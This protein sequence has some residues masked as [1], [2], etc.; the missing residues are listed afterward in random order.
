M[1]SPE[2][3]RECEWAMVD[4]CRR[5]LIAFSLFLFRDVSYWI[6]HQGAIKGFLTSQT[7]RLGDR[8]IHFQSFYKYIRFKDRRTFC[9]S[10]I[11]FS[12]HP[13]EVHIRKSHDENVNNDSWGESQ[14]FFTLHRRNAYLKN[15]LKILSHRDNT[16]QREESGG[17]NTIITIN[18]IIRDWT[19]S[20][21]NERTLRQQSLSLN[22]VIYNEAKPGSRKLRRPRKAKLHSSQT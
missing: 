8:F 15:I 4:E 13:R 11:I 3:R 1:N 20:S 16:M 18:K 7:N 2:K 10:A 9:S 22:V 19:H 17:S 14:E 5:E 21:R 6:T 12:I